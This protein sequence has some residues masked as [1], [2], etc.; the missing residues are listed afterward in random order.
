MILG[1]GRSA[2]D[3]LQGGDEAHDEDAATDDG[4]ARGQ[5]TLLLE[6]KLILGFELLVLLL[7]LLLLLFF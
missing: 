3:R 5:V 1:I 2:G 7:L 6:E 4:I